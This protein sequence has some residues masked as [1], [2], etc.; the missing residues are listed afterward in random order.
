MKAG[1]C[2]GESVDFR[3]KIDELLNLI[4]GPW[5]SYGSSIE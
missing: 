5:G 3:Q 4:Q 1:I 2:N